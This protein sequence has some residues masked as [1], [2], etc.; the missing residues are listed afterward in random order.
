MIYVTEA[1][2]DRL[3]AGLGYTLAE[4][5]ARRQALSTGKGLWVPTGARAEARLNGVRNE[6]L[7]YRN[8][9]AM[10][11]GEDTDLDNEMV[12]ISAYY[13]GLGTWGG[14]MYP[15]ANDNASGVAVMLEMIRSW[16]EWGF[17]PKRT[18]LFVAWAGGERYAKPDVRAW[19]S[20]HSGFEDFRVLGVF[21]V[22]GVGAGQGDAPLLWRSSSERVSGMVHTAARKLDL[23]LTDH[24]SGL[25]SDELS[26]SEIDLDYPR[27]YLGWPGA[28][29]NTHLPADT[30]STLDSRNLER[31]GRILSLTAAVMLTDPAY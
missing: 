1:T 30:P 16:K 17:K 2:A 11:P 28:D 31:A 24:G 9:L 13:D 29:A 4:L 3:L 23:P 21:E 10:W 18:T 8:V 25:H 6:E 20:A 5:R 19:L 15:G 22:E 14:V 27:L 12:I 26:R 7:T